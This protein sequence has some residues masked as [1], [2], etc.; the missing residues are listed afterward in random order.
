[1]KYLCDTNILLQVVRGREHA[2]ICAKFLNR[3]R[4]EI[5]IT[6][7]TLFSY[8]LV[9]EAKGQEQAAH[10][11]LSFLFDAGMSLIQTPRYNALHGLLKKK[12]M[13]FDY[14]DY[15]QYQAAKDHGLTIVTLDKDFLSNTALDIHVLSP[16]DI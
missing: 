5:A 1:M 8:S 9:L 13:K 14:D 10:Q 6:D 16:Q 15:L 2:K 11:F 7:F 3:N 4:T 12:A